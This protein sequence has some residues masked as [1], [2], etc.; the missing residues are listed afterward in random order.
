MRSPYFYA[1]NLYW[2]MPVGLRNTLRKPA[3]H[4]AQ[5]LWG[6]RDSPSK[7][8]F[9]LTSRSADLT[10]AQFQRNVLNHAGSYKGVF[11]QNVLIGWD[12]ELYQRPQHMAIAFAEL[13]Y[14]VIYQTVRWAADDVQGFRQVH[15]NVW[16]TSYNVVDEV[17]GSV[18]S[19]YSTDHAI[20]PDEFFGADRSTHRLVYEYIDH[21]DPRI[22]G[23]SDNIRSLQALKERAFAGGVDYI[24]A[25]ATSLYEEAA[26]A[27][28]P[29]KVLLVPNGVNTRHY[30]RRKGDTAVS[31]EF[32]AFMQKHEKVVGYFGALAPWIWYDEINRLVEARPDLGFIFIG[33]DYYG[34]LDRISKAQN[35]LCT[36]PISY[37]DLPAYAENFDIC[38]IPFEPGEIARTTSP[39]KLFEYFAL[40]K[41]VV[42]T[43]AMNECVRFPEV[44]A[45]ADAK[46][47]SVEI[48][49]AFAVKDD[50]AFKARL[51]SLADENDWNHRA[52][53]YEKVF[54]GLKR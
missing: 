36:G 32:R 54:E 25:S 6:L 21:I 22:S 38:F 11:I 4:I 45:G 44:F 52:G 1:R 17:P 28:G 41:P 23:S 16:L 51:A 37:N 5:T 43:S 29:E 3:R 18:V 27:V 42:V 49:R 33:P 26:G 50:P 2:N 24:V 13:G 40:E 7:S 19:V 34:G 30:R 15:P 53:A 10:W 47:L 48:D 46:E 31:P 12:V 14:L 35:V 20:D 39:L 9:P 8:R